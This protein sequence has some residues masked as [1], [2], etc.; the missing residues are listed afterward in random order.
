MNRFRAAALVALAGLGGC[1]VAPEPWTDIQI[2]GLVQERFSRLAADEEPVTGP[3]DL[4]EAMAR[5]LKYN[6]DHRV[7]QLGAAIKLREIDLAH[8]SLLPNIVANSGYA[9]RDNDNASNSVNVLTGVQS[10]ATSTSQERRLSTSDA[11][12]SWN[13][14]DFGLSYVRARQAADK[15]LIAE[16]LRRRAINRLIED[17]RTAY[18]RAV[19]SDQLIRR[20]RQLE[21]RIRRAQ[22]NARHASA[23]RQTSPIVAATNEREL[24]DIK[25]IVHELQRDLSVARTQ[26]AALMNLKPGTPFVLSP[27]RHSSVSSVVMPVADMI[28]TALRNR[29]ELREVWYQKR[30]AKHELDAALL[31]LIPSLGVYAGSNYDSNDFLYNSNWV[32][33]GA[34]ASWNLL[35]VIQYPAK[36]S[37]VEATA[38]QLAE[39]ELALMMA[40]ATQVHVSRIRVLQAAKE[41]RIAQEYVETQRRLTGLVRAEASAN[42]VG[43]QTL[44]REE[45]TLLVGEAR[46]SIA[47]AGLQS[48]IASVYASMGLD[49]YSPVL[50]LNTNVQGVAAHLRNLRIERGALEGAR[51][52]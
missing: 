19:S 43:E 39:R 14:L 28:E 4:Y 16:E 42:R 46:R 15:A 5:A 36:R 8:Y 50:D 37:V 33:W 13:V 34:K 49:P 18:W 30:I 21:T 35:R 9:A 31:E 20:L 25:R 29:S 41:V 6:L 32:N 10:L 22:V 47:H 12:F 52:P 48:A 44:I 24:I 3:I 40:I 26:L 2:S 23:D 38:Q 17:V 51:R 27:G 7:E 11:V 45:M 1:A